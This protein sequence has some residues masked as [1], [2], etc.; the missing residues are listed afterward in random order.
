M[1]QFFRFACAAIALL[2]LSTVAG[3]AMAADAV[4][5]VDLQR[6][7]G[8][9]VAGKSAQAQLKSIGDNVQKELDPEA[10]ALQ[11]EKDA[12]WA[13][14]F[15]GKSD[16]QAAAELEKDPALKSKYVAYVERGNALVQ[17]SQLRRGELQATEQAA[18][19][20]VIEAASPDV[21]GAM[22]AKGASVVLEKGA[23]VWATDA[24]DVTADVLS[25]FNARVKTV[26]VT[27]VDLTQQQK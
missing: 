24:V 16:Q 9:S 26:P 7:Y 2:G 3:P 8:E 11:T 27:K 10:K 13:P 5:V 12:T 21:K 23:V 15:K 6:L 4:V 18:V 20:A 17:K 14:R 1:S 25:R 19:Q 22:A